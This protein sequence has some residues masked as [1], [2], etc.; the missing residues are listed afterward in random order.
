MIGRP[1]RAPVLRLDACVAR[2]G[3][4]SRPDPGEMNNIEAPSAP[5]PVKLGRRRRVAGT[6]HTRDGSG[7]R[8]AREPRREAPAVAPGELLRPRLAPRALAPLPD[9]GGDESVLPDLRDVDP[10]RLGGPVV[11]L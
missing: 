11:V 6:G 8:P 9:R 4:P 2:R 3:G 5:P 10:E 1:T 7:V